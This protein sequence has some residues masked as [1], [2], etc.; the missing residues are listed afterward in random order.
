[1]DIDK[2]VKI[3]QGLEQHGKAMHQ[4]L[5]MNDLKRLKAQVITQ[6][7]CAGPDV[8]FPD[9]VDKVPLCGFL[10]IGG[11][12]RAFWLYQSRV[13]SDPDQPMG[14]SFAEKLEIPGI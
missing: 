10:T 2:K 5:S 4:D 12:R 7:E 13:P 8:G 3:Y 1:M 11:K 9:D 6:E 14:L